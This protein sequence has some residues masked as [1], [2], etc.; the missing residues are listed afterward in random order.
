MRS[1]DVDRDDYR[2]V[3]SS[4]LKRFEPPKTHCSEA[5]PFGEID[6]ERLRYRQ[7][8]LSYRRDKDFRRKT[9]LISLLA[10]SV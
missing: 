7:R 3:R 8:C 2:W 1:S 5:R 4:F 6:A 10:Y 9:P